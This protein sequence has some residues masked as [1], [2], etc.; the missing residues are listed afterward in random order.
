MGQMENTTLDMVMPYLNQ[1]SS[2]FSDAATS[3]QSLPTDAVDGNP[4]EEASAMIAKVISVS[5]T[6]NLIYYSLKSVADD[7]RGFQHSP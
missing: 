5:I 2:A 3:M 7:N 1:L 6:V 4:S